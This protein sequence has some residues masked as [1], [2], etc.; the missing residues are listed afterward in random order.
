MGNNQQISSLTDGPPE[1]DKKPRMTLDL[2][3]VSINTLKDDLDKEGDE[4]KQDAGGWFGFLKKHKETDNLPSSSPPI[5]MG[6]ATAGEQPPADNSFASAASSSPP[7][8][9]TDGSEPKNSPE[10]PESSDSFLDK[11]LDQFKAQSQP[12]RDAESEELDAVSDSSEKNSS[13]TAEAP[14]N[15]PIADSSAGNS[16]FPSPQPV[17][18]V[19]PSTE[20]APGETKKFEP[21]SAAVPNA[22]AAPDALA[23][24]EKPT[25]GS[26]FPKKEPEP[27]ETSV[28]NE[29]AKALS[30]GEPAKTS[31]LPE[32]ETPQ[33]ESEEEKNPFS[34]HLPKD[35]REKGS[36][37][38]AV[39]SALN[40]S[41]PPEFS[42]EREA[43]ERIAEEE[44]SVVDLR[45][46]AETKPGGILKNKKMLIIFGGAGGLILILVFATFLF[47]GGKGTEKPKA[48]TSVPEGNKN[49][50]TN[51]AVPIKQIITTPAKPSLPPQKVLASAEEVSIGSLDEISTEI[52][53]IRRSKAVPKQTQLVFVGPEGAAVSF[54][55]LI[56]SLN[57][58]IP[59][60][61]LPQPD[62]V[63]ALFFTDFFH[64]QTIFGI[65]IPTA[66][67]TS[68]AAAE[69]QDWEKTMVSDLDQLWKGIPTDNPGA[70]FADSNVFKNGRFALIDKKDKFS[71]DYVVDEGY[72]FITCGKDSMSILRKQFTGISDASAS[73]SG[74]KWEEGG[75]GT[76][77]SGAGTSTGPSI[78]IGSANTDT[79]NTY[80]TDYAGSNG[81]EN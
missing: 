69:M 5:A 34:A 72:I 54:Q 46:K 14:P 53:K 57:I 21:D 19:H 81:S 33:S 15:L 41:A 74:I 10:S 38:Q 59:K 58:N 66:D 64:G 20:F 27:E 45:K 35:K 61:V 7:D 51:A 56:S 9:W 30:G 60:K 76:Q 78:G 75:T 47:L 55:E 2:Q 48:Q 26:F 8:G 44:G 70:Y 3:N 36:L 37:I 22:A 1:D 31:E 25:L 77:Q 32:A 42:E 62:S 63:P 49:Q 80:N 18:S 50:N 13:A 23:D 24:Q 40:Y 6:G 11:E 43:Q 29:L 71:L 17:Y 73:G 12:V 39:E 67:G 4:V 68:A 52:E 28:Q 79:N 65:I 16:D